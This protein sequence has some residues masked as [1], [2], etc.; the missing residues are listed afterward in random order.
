MN[1][2]KRSRWERF[3]YPK[4]CGFLGIFKF[5]AALRRGFAVFLRKNRRVNVF[6]PGTCP[7]KNELKKRVIIL[8]LYHIEKYTAIL[9]ANR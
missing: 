6:F 7:W 9:E 4:I 2:K 1:E 3:F 5:G 8:C